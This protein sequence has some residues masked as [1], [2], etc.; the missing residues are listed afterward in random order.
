METTAHTCA[1]LTVLCTIII[2]II[3]IQANLASRFKVDA[4][5]TLVFVDGKT[6]KLISKEGRSIVSDD[7]NGEQFP[8]KPKPFL[9]IM[10]GAKLTDQNRKEIEWEQLQGKTIALFFSAHW[11]GYALIVVL[12]VC[13]F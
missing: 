5:P 7:P 6:G 4:I 3:I 8:W 13:L 9:D 11:V 12:C 2:I 1:F 10:A